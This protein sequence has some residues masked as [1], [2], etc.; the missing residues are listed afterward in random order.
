MAETMTIDSFL[1]MFHS[2][3]GNGIGQDDAGANAAIQ[4]LIRGR[5]SFKARD[6]WPHR[7]DRLCNPARLDQGCNQ[8]ERLG[9]LEFIRGAADRTSSSQGHPV[10]K[11][12]LMRPQQQWGMKPARRAYGHIMR[13]LR[14]LWVRLRWQK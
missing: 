3:P 5:R 4:R 8:M 9:S 14:N 2:L 6:T 11:S 1:H 12:F 13:M 10:L 7:A